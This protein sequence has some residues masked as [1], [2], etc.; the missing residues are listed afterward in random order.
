MAGERRASGT[1]AIRA[2]GRVDSPG[3]VK[4][5]LLR[6]AQGSAAVLLLPVIEDI[7]ERCSVRG[8]A[9]LSEERFRGVLDRTNAGEF[10]IDREG[11][12]CVRQ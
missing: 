12:F 1:E 6:D 11:S 7:S 2:E 5:N 9:R 8:I 3:E 10:F 4:I